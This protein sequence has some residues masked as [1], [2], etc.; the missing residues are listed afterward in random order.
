MSEEIAIPT[1]YFAFAVCRA[2][3][4]IEHVLAVMEPEMARRVLRFMLE[5]KYVVKRG[6]RYNLRGDRLCNAY[7]KYLRCYEHNVQFCREPACALEVIWGCLSEAGL[8]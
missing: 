1:L 2:G 4:S 5:N 3:K 8:A 6:Q 7:D